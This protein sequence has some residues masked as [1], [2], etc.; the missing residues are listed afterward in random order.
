M[1]IINQPCQIRQLPY[2]TSRGRA[3]KKALPKTTN[4]MSY[5]RF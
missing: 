2:N 4:D 5:I 1:W 3:S